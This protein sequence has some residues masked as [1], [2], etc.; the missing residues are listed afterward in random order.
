MESAIFGFIGALIGSVLG[1]MGSLLST[2]GKQKDTQ[3]EV[4]TSVVTGERAKWR[5]EMRDFGASFVSIALNQSINTDKSDV[6][7][8]ERVRV[9]LR[10][11]LNANPDHALDSRLLA[12]LPVILSQVR[13]GS[14]DELRASLESF[15]VTLQALLKQEWDKSKGEAESGNIAT[16]DSTRSSAPNAAS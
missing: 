2:F 16:P 10:L 9:H 15:E 7:E 14:N 6:S 4:R 3:L 12:L 8:L 1:F 13:Q 5:A 11:R